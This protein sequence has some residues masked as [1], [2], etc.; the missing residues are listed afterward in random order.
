MQKK[1]EL[2]NDLAEEAKK[3]NEKLKDS[4][5][6]HSLFRLNQYGGV[7]KSFA[8]LQIAIENTPGI[9]VIGYDEFRH[10][11]TFGEEKEPIDDSFIHS[12]RLSI[13]KQHDVT[14]SKDDVLAMLEL[15][16]RKKKAYHPVKEKIEA[17]QWDGVTRAS[18]I[19]ID[20]LGA[21]NN[22]YVKEVTK[23]WLVGAIARI[24]EPG[25][26]F[27]IVPVLN[28]KQG[29]GKSTLASKLGGEF[30]TDSLNALGD[31]KDDY[32]QLIGKWII[33]LGEL[34]S[35]K[36]TDNDKIKNFLSA[37]SDDIRLPYDRITKKFKRTSV[38]I[39]TTNNNEYLSDLTGSRRFYP[40][41]LD[42]EPAK[43]VFDMR[44]ADIQQIWAEAKTYYELGEEIFISGDF[45]T[46][47][48]DYRRNASKQELFYQ[49]IEDYLEMLVPF[50]WEQKT[51]YQKRTYY[52]RYV[53]DN[54]TDKGT[55]G[56]DRTTA[57]EI[58]RVVFDLDGGG[59]GSNGVLSKIN[60]YMS[61]L[62][63]WKKQSV[64]IDGKVKKGFKRVT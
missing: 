48:E 12:V 23:K 59:R 42:N 57:K 49:D 62:P 18:H 51:L 4:N 38:F 9:D 13:D 37:T 63:G 14:F 50:D 7:K 43:S 44:E 56:L 41:P 53:N 52:N 29:R 2:P 39:G 21:E 47:A 10:L 8:N 6:V 1:K 34:S 45:E 22:E 32:Q 30:F 5:K 64:R 28:G 40:I 61:N 17:E 31:S 35:M 3:H 36:K 19:F 55:D 27:E 16:S 54:D 33:E 58:A 60:L 15:V 20:Y 26:K 46:M 11:I 25:V 24:Y